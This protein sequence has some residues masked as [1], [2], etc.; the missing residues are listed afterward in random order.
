MAKTLEMIRHRHPELTLVENS[1]EP[2]IPRPQGGEERRATETERDEEGRGRI[3]SEADIKLR[4][5]VHESNSDI[6]P[7]KARFPS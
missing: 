3:G 6:V 5:H 7:I 4:V 2:T 1:I